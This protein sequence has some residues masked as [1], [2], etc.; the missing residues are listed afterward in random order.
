MDKETTILAYPGASIQWAA[1]QLLR[2]DLRAGDIVFWLLTTTDRIDYYSES[3]RS[4]KVHSNL[5]IYKEDRDEILKLNKNEHSMLMKL[6]THKWNVYKSINVIRQVINYCNKLGVQL[7][8]GQAL[9]NDLATDRALMSLL[10]PYPGFV[11][12]F[13][14]KLYYN[15]FLLDRGTDNQHPGPLTHQYIADEFYQSYIQL[16]SLK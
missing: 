2:S 8:I 5:S 15:N 10:K 11:L 12:P 13:S 6:L 16:C 7:H 9:V 3:N 1:D 4:V 14:V